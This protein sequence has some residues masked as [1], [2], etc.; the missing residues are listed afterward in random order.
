MAKVWRILASAACASWNQ[1][2]FASEL[3]LSTFIS[4]V[5]KAKITCRNTFAPTYAVILKTGV[6]IS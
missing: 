3:K 5:I 2:I 6:N 1:Y 4:D